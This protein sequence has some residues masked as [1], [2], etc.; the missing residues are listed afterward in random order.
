MLMDGWTDRQMDEGGKKVITIAYPE[1]KLK[2]AKK[3]MKWV[4]TCF[5]QIIPL[6]S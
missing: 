2:Q 6:G 5:M 1:H 4:L 3:S